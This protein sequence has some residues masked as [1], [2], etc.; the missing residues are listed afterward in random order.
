M[1]E[2]FVKLCI[3]FYLSIVIVMKKKYLGVLL[4][5]FLGCTAKNELKNAGNQL[6][7]SSTSAAQAQEVLQSSIKD[8]IHFAFSD[9]TM[10]GDN[11]SILYD[12]S[13]FVFSRNSATPLMRFDA[14]GNYLNKIGH[15]GNGPEE[16]YEVLDVCLNRQEKTVEIL[17]GIFVY[18]YDYKGDFIEKLEHKLSAFSF[19][20]D[21]QNN[22]W[23]YQGNNKVN[24][25][26]KIIKLDSKCTQKQEFLKEKSTLLPM[27]ESNFGRG[28][29]LT[30]KESLNH[31]IY[32]IIDGQLN[33]SYSVDFEGFHLPDN[34]HE[35][36][37]MEVVSLLKNSNYASIANYQE[38]KNYLFLQV[39]LNI[40]G[41]NKPEIYYWLIQK[42][43]KKNLVIKIDAE[44]PFE[45]YL[46]Y[47][48][49]LSQDNKLYF[50]GFLIDGK[51][52]VADSENNPSL[53]AVDISKLI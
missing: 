13:Y 2:I 35:L 18:R 4:F 31:D 30:F 17:S 7:F 10:I 8:T 34:L 39:V 24:G 41:Q 52:A 51:S 15:I 40:A 36:A 33:L 20:V 12:D 42:Q 43:S 48:Q 50:L 26:A 46:Y 25:N 47:P 32:H 21:T 28:E 38:N 45:S 6:V 27:V 11:P 49:F 3:L 44:I 29:Y 37:P 23:F 16:L 5:V 1:D 14:A 9:S 53:V 22:Y 19:T